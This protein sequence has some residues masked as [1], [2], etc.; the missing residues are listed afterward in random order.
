MKC[1][2]LLMVG[3]L[4]LAG[5]KTSERANSDL[6]AVQLKGSNAFLV[7]IKDG[8]LSSFRIKGGSEKKVT[9]VITPLSEIKKEV[10]ETSLINFT[11]NYEPTPNHVAYKKFETWSSPADAGWP[12]GPLKYTHAIVLDRV[13]LSVDSRGAKNS[14]YCVMRVQISIYNN[15]GLLA[16]KYEGEAEEYCWNLDLKA[17]DEVLFKSWP[18]VSKAFANALEK[19]DTF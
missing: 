12:L 11:E 19:I 7:P 5:C 6:S 14:Y 1:F 3:L 15:A 10:I 8:G 4:W 16:G 13:D 9:L 2:S 17:R 18:H